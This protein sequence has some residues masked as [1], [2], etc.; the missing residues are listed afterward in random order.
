MFRL[1]GTLVGSTEL[2]TKGAGRKRAGALM[3]GEAEGE[4][5]SG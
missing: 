5:V 2:K 1:D 3:K 4:V